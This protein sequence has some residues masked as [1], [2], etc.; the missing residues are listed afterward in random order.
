MPNKPEFVK[1]LGLAAGSALPV[2]VP[3]PWPLA[4]PPDGWLR[5][6]GSIFGAAQYPELAKVYP[7]LRLPDLRGEFIRGWDDSGK[8]DVGR[9]L[10]SSQNFAF[11]DHYHA[12]P[13]STGVDWDKSEQGITT[14]FSDAKAQNFAWDTSQSGGNNTGLWSGN[15][16]RTYRSSVDGGVSVANETRPRNIAFNYIVRAV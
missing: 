1:N 14:V 3:I 8:V 13:T 12:L 10:L 11:Q 9:R 4:T 5:C 16:F 15:L 6:D 7:S 2:G